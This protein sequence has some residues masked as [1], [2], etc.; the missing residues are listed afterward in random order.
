[1]SWLPQG[2]ADA[3]EF[4]RHPTMPGDEARPDPHELT[5]NSEKSRLNARVYAAGLD[6]M[7]TKT[8]KL[9][10]PEKSSFSSSSACSSSADN[11]IAFSFSSKRT[12]FRSKRRKRVGGELPSAPGASQSNDF[13]GAMGLGATHFGLKPYR[14]PEKAPHAAGAKQRTGPKTRALLEISDAFPSKNSQSTRRSAA[15]VPQAEGEILMSDGW[16]QRPPLAYP[17]GATPHTMVL[18]QVTTAST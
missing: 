3:P 1:M 17:K 9:R 2:A 18:L 14:P 16:Q 4:Q 11:T 7:T 6:R 8:N 12:R 5:K 10:A 15:H 13:D